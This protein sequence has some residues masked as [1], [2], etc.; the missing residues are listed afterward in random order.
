MSAEARNARPNEY[1]ELTSKDY[2]PGAQVRMLHV[3]IIRNK[4]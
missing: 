1:G 2:V 4:K 3:I